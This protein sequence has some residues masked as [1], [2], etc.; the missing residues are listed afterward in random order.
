MNIEIRPFDLIHA[1]S[2]DWSRFDEYHKSMNRDYNPDQTLMDTETWRRMRQAEL[3]E[4]DMVAYEAIDLQQDDRIA[5]FFRLMFWK[6]SSPS[7][8]GNEHICAM[9]GIGV[10]NE[11]RRKGIATKLLP[12]IYDEVKARG[13]QS[14]TGP[15]VNE[16]A[17]IFVQKIGGTEALAWQ[18]NRLDLDSV[19]WV[20]VKDWVKDGPKRSPGTRIEF[21][22]TI[23]DKILEQYCN[24]YTEVS[25]Q[26]P[27]DQLKVGDEIT[28]PESW[29]IRMAR[30]AEGRMKY[31]AA[32]TVERNGDISGLTDVAWFPSQPSILQQWL[33]GVQEKYRGKGL[34]KWLKGAVLL[35]VRKEFPAVTTVSTQNA[36][37]NGPM[38]AINRQLGFKMYKEIYQF[39]MELDKLGDYLGR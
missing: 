13:K 3:E 10:R 26:A 7:Y 5:G 27:R 29:K 9:A 17:H 4:L 34:G 36:T 11:Y 24:V 2:S 35:R 37:S 39:Q 25:N 15:I 28:T 12:V 33:T 31:L 14:L 6:D 30:F 19:D 18:D 23:P 21:F 22:H 20:M 1:S 16:A 8:R 38:L 32:L